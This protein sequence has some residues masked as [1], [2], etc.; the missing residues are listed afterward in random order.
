[1]MTGKVQ[2]GN[3]E[4]EQLPPSSIPVAGDTTDV[5]Q[6]RA[7]LCRVGP[8][9]PGGHRRTQSRHAAGRGSQQRRLRTATGGPAGLASV[10]AYV[11]Q[12][13]HN[14][15]DVF[16]T[17]LNS[18]GMVYENGQLQTGQLMNWCL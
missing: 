1:M 4:F 5:G 7:E 12:T 18:S 8:I 13:G 16:W 6:D 17:F 14:I 2:I 15:A 11:P 10:A 3:S 9:N